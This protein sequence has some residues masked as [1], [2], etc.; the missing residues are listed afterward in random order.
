VTLANRGSTTLG[1]YAYG[2]SDIQLFQEFDDH[3]KWNPEAWD[4]CGSGLSEYKLAPGQE[5]QLYVAFRDRRRER[6]QGSFTESET[7]RR[8]P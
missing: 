6:M 2:P 3:A 5:V 8:R 4:W 1:Y 7:N